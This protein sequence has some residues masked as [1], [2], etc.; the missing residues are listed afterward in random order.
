MAAP[1]VYIFDGEDEFAI[2]ESVFNLRQKLGEPSIADLNT[3]TLD[4]RSISLV[5]LE[6]AIKTV[7][8]LAVR[9]LVIVN[10]PLARINDKNN[11][12]KF[13]KLM[14]NLP[15]TSA[16]VLVI[17]G[18]LTLEKDRKKGHLHWL[19]RWAA[20]PDQL[21]RVF[22]RH[23]PVPEG[24][25]LVRWIQDQTRKLGGQITPQAASLLAGQVGDDTRLV[26]QEITKLLTYAN[27]SRP[28]EVDDVVHLTPSSA[29]V[30]DFD[31][32]NALRARDSRKAQSLL[33]RML[34]DEDPQT[35][36]QGIVFQIRCLL[37]AREILDE[38][39]TVADFPPALKISPYPAR[40]ALEA[41]PRYT[42]AFLD[43]TYHRLLDLDEASK[44]GR[45][46]ASLALEL[47]V[48]ELT[49]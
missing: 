20:A 5:Q 14:S 21:E 47:L 16:L 36:L 7:P 6:E 10:H 11:Q 33:Q 39:G 17:D 8:F 24:A 27:Y 44:T 49:T 4:G 45:M 42:Q 48:V 35:I 28:V 15:L 34:Q 25:M 31:L 40:L 26:I 32:V 37:V 3:T 46:E 13:I 18:N 22:L 1:I 9:R 38:H 41:A 30:G 19:E 43:S 2:H 29:Q 23:H 12:E